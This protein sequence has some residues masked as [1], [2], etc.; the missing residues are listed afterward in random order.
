[1]KG[2]HYGFADRA[3]Q[4]VVGCDNTI[5]CWRE[6]WA[7]RTVNRLAAAPNAEVAKAHEGLVRIAGNGIMA[8]TGAA[9][10][11]EKH[12][13]DPLRWRKPAVVATGFH[14]DWGLLSDEDKARMFWTMGDARAKHH[15][16]FPLMKHRLGKTAEWLDYQNVIPNVNIGY[17]LMTQADADAA[18]PHMRAIARAGWK[19]HVWHEPAIGPI[20]WAGWEFLTMI[21]TGG[22]SGKTARPMHPDWA[23]IDRD[24]CVANG[25]AF[26]FKQWGEWAPD[27]ELHSR[28]L[29][30]RFDDDEI[31][32][33]VGK[34]DAGCL[35]D[36]ILWKQLP[37]R[38][39]QTPT[40]GEE[41]GV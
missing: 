12:L 39:R 27:E 26:R 35:L 40:A 36:G 29:K 34:H 31:V 32:Y 6:C 37:S 7:K 2:L 21:V 22:E 3:W 15:H 17:S 11:N 4:V 28:F 5:P 24:F 14:G 33:R 41:Q 16:F 38:V 13:N 19:T 10:I 9:R 30:Y 1:M 18:L 20:N 8:W 25:I 23:R